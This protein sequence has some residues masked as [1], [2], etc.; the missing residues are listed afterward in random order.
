MA[1]PAHDTR[2]TYPSGELVQP[3]RVLHVA[4]AGDGLVAVLTDVTSF[5]PVDA[6][7][8][9]Q[10]ADTGVIAAHG[11][12]LHVRD[13]VV[14]AS[15]GTALHLGADIPVRKGTEGWAFLVAHLVDDDA[16]IAEGD[17]V[18]IVADATARRD[19][20]LGHTACHAAS[21]ALNLA[22]A[23][24]WSKPARTDALDNP[25]FDGI[26]IATSRIEPAASL[27]RYR[28]NKSLRRAGFD[29]A[30]L[31]EADLDDLART[32]TTTVQGWVNAN[33]PV[34]IDRDGEGLTDR[35]R[36]VAELPVGTAEIPCGGT[37]ADSLGELGAVHVSLRLVDD[38]G[39][40]VLEMR[41]SS[42]S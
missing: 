32:V 41:T 25:D 30:G 15:D 7:W 28:L 34:R 16:A 21:L 26:A 17:L 19:L 14:A 42:S 38:E 4:P 10:P 1:L 5:H 20:S 29:V 33:A 35:R 37:H 18:A 23:S 36:W 40:P 11:V 13:A 27:D 39:T 9:D 3:A 6:A 12:D 8:P 24:R 22:L 31:L 2:V